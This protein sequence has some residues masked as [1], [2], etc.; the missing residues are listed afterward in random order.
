MT[1]NKTLPTCIRSAIAVLPLVW[2]IIFLII[3]FAFLG[4]VFLGRVDISDP[5]VAGLL[6]GIIAKC[7]DVIMSISVYLYG[8]DYLKDTKSHARESSENL[9]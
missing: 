6:G 8:N 3:T 9:S 2:G 1:N 4:V 5:V 7:M